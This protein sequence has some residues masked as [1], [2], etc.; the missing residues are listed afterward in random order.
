MVDSRVGNVRYYLY[1]IHDAAKCDGRSSHCWR[2]S[3]ICVLSSKVDY[4]IRATKVSQQFAVAVFLVDQYNMSVRHNSRRSTKRGLLTTSIRFDYET[5]FVKQLAS[6]NLV[7]D[8]RK[9][10]KHLL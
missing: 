4:S 9:E 6:G 1:A 10:T 8:S 2:S 3:D 7:C 5:K